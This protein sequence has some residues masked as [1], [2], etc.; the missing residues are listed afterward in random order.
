MGRSAY[1]VLLAAGLRGGAPITRA[2]GTRVLRKPLHFQAGPTRGHMRLGSRPEPHKA[3]AVQ[4]N[5][6]NALGAVGEA[7]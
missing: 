3:L 5:R 1:N 2:T 7:Y 4:G 6:C